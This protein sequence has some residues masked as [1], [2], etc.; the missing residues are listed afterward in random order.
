[1]FEKIL[2]YCV[3]M[4]LEGYWFFG[5]VDVLFVFDRICEVLYFC[6]VVWCFYFYF[7]VVRFCDIDSLCI[8]KVIGVMDFEC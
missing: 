8:V 4:G 5:E 6:Y 7:C 3:Y 1:M 2:E